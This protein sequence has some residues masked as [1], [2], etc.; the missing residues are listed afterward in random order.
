MPRIDFYV[1]Q[2]A[3]IEARLEFVVK[4]CQKA[5]NH[6]L[7]TLIHLSDHS[8][9]IQ[10]DALLWS[11]RPESFI[12]HALSPIPYALSPAS[13][14]EPPVM[15]S[16]ASSVESKGDLLINLTTQPYT[17]TQ[18]YERAAEVVI[19]TPPILEKTRAHYRHY[20]ELGYELHMHQL[21]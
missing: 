5:L 19:Q 1:L 2:S 16:T 7:S 13:S 18:N 17:Q 11:L 10:L 8:Q 4:L 21:A 20:K 12:P 3:S 6:N 9:A 15:L 14:P